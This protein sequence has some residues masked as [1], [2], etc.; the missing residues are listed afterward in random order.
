M[1]KN[2]PQEVGG[3]TLLDDKLRDRVTNEEGEWRTET[4]FGRHKDAM[5]EIG[6]ILKRLKAAGQ[7]EFVINN[8]G[9]GRIRNSGYKSF[10]TF[11][12][13]NQVERAGITPQELRLSVYDRVLPPLIAV[14]D[15]KR[16][17]LNT[18]EQ[19]RLKD[20]SYTKEFFP[21]CQRR[22]E[23][24]TI[25]VEISKEWVKRIK[26][27]HAHLDEMPAI[28]KADISFACLQIESHKFNLKN[29]VESTKEGG[30]I[31]CNELAKSDMVTF[32]LKRICGEGENVVYQRC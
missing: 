31:V 24:G 11:E 32:K 2:R 23:D 17:E 21:S 6:K 7:M 28:E 14:E 4:W 3:R 15:T 5:R 30:F 19:L 18:T 29:L 8:F 25:A 22:E 26:S 9:P 13:I 27:F 10:E 1:H 20:E 16:I 12:L